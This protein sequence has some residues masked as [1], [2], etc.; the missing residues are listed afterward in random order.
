MSD[1]IQNVLDM[2]IEKEPARRYSSIEELLVDLRSAISNRPNLGG[3]VGQEFSKWVWPL[4][5]AFLLSLGLV[6]L[7]GAFDRSV[8]GEDGEAPRPELTRIAVLPFEN[9]SPDP[10]NEYF[11]VI[12]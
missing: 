4:V 8:P 7:L 1:Q 12:R 9:M 11:R 10:G 3:R 6:W 5:G 2:M